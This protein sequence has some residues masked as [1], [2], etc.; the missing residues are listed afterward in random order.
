MPKYMRNVEVEDLNRNFWVI[1]QSIAALSAFLFED[2]PITDLLKRILN[3]IA[4]LWQN[5]MYLWATMS[6]IME[7]DKTYNVH[8][9]VIVLPNDEL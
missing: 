2:S 8:T 5:I 3:E 6:M 9:E 1:G 7:D 4:Q